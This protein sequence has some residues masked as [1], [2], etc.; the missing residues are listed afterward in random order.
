MGPIMEY[1]QA[2]NSILEDDSGATGRYATGPGWSTIYTTDGSSDDEAYGKYGIYGCT[3]EINTEFQP[4]YASMRDKTVQRQR[5]AW[6]FFL[7]R[8][9]STPSIQGHVTDA[10]TGQPLEANVSLEEVVFTHGEAPRTAN[11]HGRYHW[12]GERGK[13]YHAN[14][15]MPG[16]I[17]QAHAVTVGEGISWQDVALV[18]TDPTYVPHDPLPGDKATGQPSSVTVSWQCTGVTSFD[19]HFG[20]SGDPP[21]VATVSDDSYTATGLEVGKTYFWKIVANTATGQVS[22]PIWSFSTYPYGVTAVKKMGNPFRLNVTGA[23]F[24]EGCSVMING[25]AVPETVY[26]GS[27]NLLA[28]GGSALKAMAPKGI[29]VAITVQDASGGKSAPFT[30]SW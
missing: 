29:P 8:T 7:D 6:Q 9:L 24:K 15:S 2:L 5:T 14:Y 30:F 12:L 26:K 10:V 1:G 19:V 13:T 20:L 28:R 27:A 17:S 21:K 4:D 11:R 25:A 3:I 22:G 18:P 16:Y 23:G